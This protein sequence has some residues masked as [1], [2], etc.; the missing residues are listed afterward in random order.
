MG[1]LASS[2]V[3]FDVVV[4]GSGFGGS[5]AA[6]RLTEKGYRVAVVE[7][8]RRF[9]DDEFAE[10][11]WDLRKYLWAPKLGCFGIQRIHLLR[12][13]M[14]LAGSGVGGGSLVYANTLYRPLKPFFADRQ[15]A[16]ITDWEAELSPFYDQASRMLGV[17]TNPTTTP[18]DVVMQ[19]V[20][21]DMGVA[22]SYHPTPVGVYFGEPGVEVADPYFGGA[23]PARTGCTECGSCMSGCRVGAKNTLVKNYLHLA[24]RGGARVLPLTTVTGL[25]QTGVTWEVDTERTGAKLRKGRRTIT[26]TKVVLAAGTWGTQQLLHRMRAEGVLPELSPRLGELTRTNSES[27]VGAARQTVDPDRDFTS[28]VAITS[29]FHPDETTHIEPCRYGKGSNVMGM[30]QTLAT[31]GASSTPRVLQ[32]LRQAVR[33]PRRLLRLLS[34]RQW[35]ERTLI[36]LVMQSLDNSITTFAKRGLFGRHKLSSRQGHGEPNPTFIPA[37]HRANELTAKHIGGIAGGT[38]GELAGIPLTAHFIGGCPIGEDAEHGVI[39]PYHRVHHY[40]GLSVVDGAA[41]SANLGVN[42]SLTI[43]AQAER[44]FSLWPNKGEADPRPE[45]GAGYQRV[46]PVAPTTPAVPAS[47]P[48]ALRLP[49]VAITRPVRST[50]A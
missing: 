14:V 41:I 45:P 18:A 40:P 32:F 27:I 12:N 33:H 5:V 11:S 26:A 43:T 35:S 28:G 29:S 15:W 30:L 38:W 31:D 25:R 4:V 22:D 46:A 1:E 10:T 13:V 34:V 50:P 48:G 6:L 21:G 2:N 17:V 9:A 47:A 3:D 20:A 39:D 8:G 42:P 36:L 16:H 49:I 19:Q 37:G 23:G 24:E 7:A 44:A